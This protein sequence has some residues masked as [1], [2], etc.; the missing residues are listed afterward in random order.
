[1]A[2]A[3][4]ARDRDRSLGL[5]RAVTTWGLGFG[6]SLEPWGLRLFLYFGYINREG[7]VCGTYSIAFGI[8]NS[9]R[10]ND[11]DV[12]AVGFEPTPLRTGA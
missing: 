7:R 3:S 10:Y 8:M 6:R 5:W 12:T 11:G 9:M 4:V 2:R 1:M